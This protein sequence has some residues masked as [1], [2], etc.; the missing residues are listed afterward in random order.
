[1]EPQVN[2]ILSRLGKAQK[3]E[4]KSKK[5]ELMDKKA[6][7]KYAKQSQSLIDEVEKLGAKL[8]DQ[9]LNVQLKV[10]EA[11]KAARAAEKIF[12]KE[13]KLKEE[14]QKAVTLGNILLSQLE[15]EAKDLG[16]DFRDSKLYDQFETYEAQLRKYDNKGI[17]KEDLDSMKQVTKD[18]SKVNI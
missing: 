5:I 16:L 4:L 7:N 15:L 18:L 17:S 11:R 9:I 2:K 10:D 8:D 12:A 3:T 14:I 1:M 13:P 6:V